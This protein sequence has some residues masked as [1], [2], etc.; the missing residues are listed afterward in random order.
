MKLNVLLRWG[1]VGLWLVVAVL[2]LTAWKNADPG[3]AE[4]AKRSALRKDRAAEVHGS[5]VPED[6]ATANLVATYQGHSGCAAT[7]HDFD[8]VVDLLDAGNNF[9]RVRN[10]L[11]EGQAIK[12][13]LRDGMLVLGT[14]KMGPYEVSGYV[15][16][17]DNPARV[18]THVRYE[19][20]IG[21][22]DDV[23]IFHKRR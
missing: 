7:N 17:L 6:P 23:S 4:T 14:Q 18:E 13:K 19:D 12:A 11:D 22:C 10:L 2:P 8:I 9:F 20:G 3:S 21:Y 16:Y 1:A 15:K 5:A